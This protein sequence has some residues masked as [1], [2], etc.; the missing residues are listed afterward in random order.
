[1]KRKRTPLMIIDMHTHYMPVEMADGLRERRSAPWIGPGADG[2]EEI[3][4]PI[5][6]LAFGPQYTDMEARLDFMDGLGVDRQ[7]LSF[8][9]LF[10]LDSR[11]ADEAAPLLRLFNDDVSALCARHPDRFAGV[12]ALPF[13]DMTQVLAEFRRARG[14]LGLI[15]AVLPNNCF[16]SLAEAEK[17]RPLFELG[18]QLGAHFFIHPGR[19]PDEVPATDLQ[20]GEWPFTDSMLQRQA[21]NVQAMVANAMATLLFTDFLDPYP[22]VSVHVANLGGTLPMVIERM[23][24]SV[25]LRTP[26]APL[27][28]SRARRVHVDCSSL[29]PRSLELAV[30]VYGADRIVVGTD[31]PIFRT[32]WTL[33]AISDANIT[34]QQRDAIRGGNALEL[35]RR[36]DNDQRPGQ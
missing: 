29:G 13:A 36:F 34:E 12:A 4:L 3:H 28:S 24:H 14:E 32:D 9:S 11:P 33:Q 8:P 23:D 22:D 27:P 25:K 31:C 16:A 26:E 35:L 17:L 19:R 18:Q 15:G 30:A 10:G 2:G 6:S 21:L 7:L 20:P 5:G 1:M